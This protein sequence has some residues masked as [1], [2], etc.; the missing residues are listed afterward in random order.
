M[1][2]SVHGPGFNETATRLTPETSTT[3]GVET[4]K[5]HWPASPEG[6]AFATLVH[7]GVVNA[8]ARTAEATERD[9]VIAESYR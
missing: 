2:P 3:F 7:M 8:I 4:R 1:T 6:D 9:H 5:L